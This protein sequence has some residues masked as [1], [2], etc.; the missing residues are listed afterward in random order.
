MS[1]VY[2]KIA[3]EV[4][5]MVDDIIKFDKPLLTHLRAEIDCAL[6]SIAK[7]LGIDMKSS[8]IKY[9][10][11]H[12]TIKIEASIIRNGM[13]VDEKETW[14]KQHASTYGLNSSDL[15]RLFMHR[16]SQYRVVGLDPK[17]VKYLIIAERTDTGQRY[18]F[19]PET[20]RTSLNKGGGKDGK[21][22]E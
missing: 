10:G 22:C 7:D 16:G 4:D 11:D 17:K 15:S 13:V 6:V 21:L 14:F 20:V 19:L 18:N 3:K 12:A 9:T 8:S 2:T 1:T 5:D